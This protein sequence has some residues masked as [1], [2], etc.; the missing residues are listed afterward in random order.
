M[1]DVLTLSDVCSLIVDCEHKTAPESTPG[2]EFGY[3]IGT[4]NIRSGRMI[5]SSA[6]RVD[7]ATFWSWSARAVLQKNDIILTREAPAGEA[8]IVDGTVP[9]CLGQ[10]TVLLRPNPDVIIPRYLHYR[11]LGPEVQEIIHSRSEGSTVAHLNVQDIRGLTL[12]D[13]PDLRPQE[14]IAALLGALDDKIAINE[15]IVATAEH[16]LEAHFAEVS[17]NANQEANLG[18]LVEFKYGKA[19]K[20]ED[21]IPGRIPVFGGN[22]VSGRHD[23]SLDDGP[24]IIVGRK[25]ANAGSVSW[26]QGPFWPIDTSFFVKPLSSDTPLEYLFFLLEAAGLRNLVGDSAIPGLNRDIALRCTVCLPD[27]GDIRIFA[28]TARPFMALGA[29]LAEESRSIAEIRDTLLPKI[30]SG[31]IRMRNEGNVVE[32]VT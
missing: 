4:P 2:R 27:P 8:A 12:G 20:E 9:V 15:R 18:D 7:E 26:S 6:K 17:R 1:S 31:E 10:R 29:Q 14:V 25:G 11:L 13:L 21:R 23:V 24:G 16:L 3:S 22:G 30:M 5:L 32:D 28:E 19:L